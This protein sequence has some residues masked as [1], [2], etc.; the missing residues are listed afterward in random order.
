MF[1]VRI[2][3][4]NINPKGAIALPQTN[5]I[6]FLFDIQEKNISFSHDF[7]KKQEKHTW[8]KIIPATL[9]TDSCS[10]PH[11]GSAQTVKNGFLHTKIRY[12]PCQNYPVT[13]DIKKA[14]LSM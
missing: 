4:L 10:C 3:S 12:I 7:F 1:P 14:T 9:T 11:C 6:K 5:L 13:F 8:V 2:K